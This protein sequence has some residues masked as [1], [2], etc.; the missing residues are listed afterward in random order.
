MNNPKYFL[1][2][3]I[4]LLHV[5][6]QTSSVRIFSFNEVL[7]VLSWAALMKHGGSSANEPKDGIKN[8]K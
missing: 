2:V 1:R 3:G 5:F 4:N 6:S 8:T 7:K